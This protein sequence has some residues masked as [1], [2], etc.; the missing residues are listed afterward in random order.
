MKLKKTLKEDLKYFKIDLN[1]KNIQ[2]KLNKKLL[3]NYMK[4]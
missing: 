1:N 3:K 2:N 4:T